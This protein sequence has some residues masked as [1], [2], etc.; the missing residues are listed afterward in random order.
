[1]PPST[2]RAAPPKR[3]P[4]GNEKEF[5]VS[6]KYLALIRMGTFY[7]KLSILGLYQFFTRFNSILLVFHSTSLKGP[8]SLHVSYPADTSLSC[9]KIG[10]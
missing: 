9:P 4:L 2:P 6:F 8:F 1:M 7:D 5:V 10:S 3:L